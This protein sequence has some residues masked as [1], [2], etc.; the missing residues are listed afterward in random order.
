VNDDALVSVVAQTEDG[1]EVLLASST[2]ADKATLALGD[3]SFR[4]HAD[5][6]LLVVAHAEP[7]ALDTL[8]TD[9]SDAAD[10]AHPLRELS[11]HLSSYGSVAMETQ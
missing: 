11:S 3:G 4:A 5:G 8:I 6:A 2:P 1:L 10:A 7:L 9:A